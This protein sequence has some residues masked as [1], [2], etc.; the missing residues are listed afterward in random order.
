[1]DIQ[2][3]VYY[4]K[5]ATSTLADDRRIDARL[6]LYSTDI[7]RGEY[8][9]KYL[10]RDIGVPTQSFATPF[11]VVM[12]PANRSRSLALPLNCSVLRSDKPVPELLNTST[13]GVWFSIESVDILGMY[14]DIITEAAAKFATFEFNVPKGFIS[15]DG[16]LY[17]LNPDNGLDLEEVILN[18][19]FSY[20]SELLKET[21]TEYPITSDVFSAIKPKIVS[22]LINKPMEDPLNNAEEDVAPT[23]QG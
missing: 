8:L 20:P 14:F 17:V 4:I 9:R 19:V 2:K 12:K 23:K 5:V 15:S 16:Y 1:M 10:T 11:N 7:A 21:D 13:L 18:G 22:E 6:I 3:L